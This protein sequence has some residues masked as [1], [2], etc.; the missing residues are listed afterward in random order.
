[1]ETY[2]IMALIIFILILT[3]YR[4]DVQTGGKPFKELS[5]TEMEGVVGSWA[6]KENPKNPAR[7]GIYT[8]KKITY[9]GHGIPLY[10]IEPGVLLDPMKLPH[11]VNIDT[12]PS[13]C[14]SPY[15]SDQGC[16][17]GAIEDIQRALSGPV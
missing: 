3:I 9:Y 5:E 4:H 1:M 16:Y 15:S 11:N 12:S 13:C 6:N 8:G 7:P 10:P 2:V 17:C 14:P